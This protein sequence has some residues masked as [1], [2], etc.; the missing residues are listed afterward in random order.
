M[1]YFPVGSLDQRVDLHEFR[2]RWYSSHLAAMQE[3]PLFP[4][5]STSPLTF[6]LLDLPTWQR[7]VVVR[8]TDRDGEWV[9]VW[10]RSTGRGGY[11]PGQLSD[12]AERV[13]TMVESKRLAQLLD[14]V[15][16]WKMTHDDEG[17]GLD[18]WQAVLEGVFGDTYHVID[19]W[20]PQSTPF[21]ELAG[22]LL[23]LFRT[24]VAPPAVPPKYARS[25]AEL[26]ERYREEP[27]D[28]NPA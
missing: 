2:E 8:L 10:K 23:D 20:S 5:A 14:R 7:P 24:S 22:F 17:H 28:D 3:P 16:F 25:F 26:A 12:M 1:R 27:P 4:P 21:A 19:R 9:V 11:E 18:G 6:R 15:Q 13:L